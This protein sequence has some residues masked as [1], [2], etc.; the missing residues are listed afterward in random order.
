MP[1]RMWLKAP[2]FD[3]PTS[4]GRPNPG[5]RSPRIRYRRHAVSRLSGLAVG[6]HGRRKFAPSALPLDLEVP[7][8]WRRAPSLDLSSPLLF[9][10]HVHPT[11]RARRDPWRAAGGRRRSLLIHTR[12]AR[13]LGFHAAGEV[14][15]RPARFVSAEEEPQEGFQVCHSLGGGTGSGMGT[16]LNSA[17]SCVRR[18]VLI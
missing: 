15:G 16:L 3:R 14:C 10:S 13:S 9:S 4:V 11:A 6:R 7:W 2:C 12:T 18:K 8:R 5:G 1:S 17:F